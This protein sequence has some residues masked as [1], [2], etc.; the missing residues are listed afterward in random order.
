MDDCITLKSELIDRYG[1]F[2]ETVDKLI[3]LVV[4]NVICRKIHVKKAYVVGSE[5]RFDIEPTTPVSPEKLSSVIDKSSIIGK[6][7]SMGNYS[8]ISNDV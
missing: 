6:K 3:L 4:V 1:K 5:V 8:V 7:L 2:S